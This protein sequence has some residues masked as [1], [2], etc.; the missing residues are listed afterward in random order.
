MFESQEVILSLHVAID[1]EI[2]NCSYV[3]NLRWRRHWFSIIICA[4]RS[5]E[6]QELLSSFMSSQVN[7]APSQPAADNVIDLSADIAGG[8]TVE[9]LTHSDEVPEGNIQGAGYWF[10]ILPIGKHNDSARGTILTKILRHDV[11]P[12]Y[13]IA[14]GFPKSLSP[15]L[16]TYTGTEETAI[17]Y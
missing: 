4:L 3:S 16:R 10:R 14:P 15:E 7:E 12:P 2:V 6:T 8:D 5:N 13:A 11:Y 1:V 9:R 17:R